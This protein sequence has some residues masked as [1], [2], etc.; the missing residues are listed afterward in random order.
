MPLSGVGASV[1]L[2][3]GSIQDVG[4][5]A[6]R[7]Q[8]TEG[9]QRSSWYDSPSSLELFMEVCNDEIVESEKIKYYGRTLEV[10]VSGSS[11][12]IGRVA[13]L[14][15]KPV[16]QGMCTIVVLRAVAVDEILSRGEQITQFTSLIVGGVEESI[17][18]GSVAADAQGLTVTDEFL[19]VVDSAMDAV[20]GWNIETHTRNTAPDFDLA[21]GHDAA[22]GLGSDGQDRFFVTDSDD[23]LVRQYEQGRGYSVDSSQTMA[24][25]PSGQTVRGIGLLSNLV[26]VDYG[27]G[28][29]AN[30]RIVFPYGAG[31]L[32]VA[33]VWAPT[34]PVLHKGM[35][36]LGM[37]VFPN[38]RAHNF[39]MWRIISGVG[40]LVHNS[41][42]VSNVHGFTSNT[43]RSASNPLDVLPASTDVLYIVQVGMFYY[44]LTSTRIY[45]LTYSTVTFLGANP[46]YEVD[47]SR[48]ASRDIDLA[49]ANA[50]PRFIVWDETY[51]RVWDSANHTFYSYDPDT[52]EE[53]SVERFGPGFSDDIV[54]ATY[55]NGTIQALVE[56]RDLRVLTS[57]TSTPVHNTGGDIATNALYTLSGCV[58]VLSTDTVYV[59][60]SDHNV[61][62]A[63]SRETRQAVP[64]L[65]ID[66][67]SGVTGFDGL[68]SDGQH[69]M[70]VTVD[71][72]LR[73]YR[74]SDKSHN[75]HY[76]AFINNT[77]DLSGV[78]F[79]GDKLYSL[80]SG[81]NGRIDIHSALRDENVLRERERGA[82]RFSYLYELVTGQVLGA[83]MGSRQLP[84][85][86]VSGPVRDSFRRVVDAEPGRLADG[87]FYPHGQ[88][89]LNDA[90]PDKVGL[91]ESEAPLIIDATQF[92]QTPKIEAVDS[93]LITQ[94]E[95]IA[96]D[97]SQ[98]SMTDDDA[99]NTYGLKRRSI[100]VDASV[101]DTES[102]LEWYIDTWGQEFSINSVQVNALYEPDD[103]SSSMV[104]ARPHSVVFID[105]P[106]LVLSRMVVLEAVGDGTLNAAITFHLVSPRQFGVG[107]TLDSPLMDDTLNDRTILIE[108]RY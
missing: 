60:Y 42:L 102:L 81:S 26:M 74:L 65:H 106:W 11:F 96:F 32:F 20:R 7:L 61:I 71:G 13:E 70:G 67:G 103:V 30:Q 14:Q 76:D 35:W 24:V 47:W 104:H 90:V 23:D 49:S 41:F 77:D 86:N 38:D 10:V 18:I 108:A 22:T 68:T 6:F 73:A 85:R 80:Y 25:A 99:V 16:E 97:G 63:Y 8:I 94:L 92:V 21:T 12:W 93:L 78:A 79:R 54:D 19:L 82:V 39:L 95:M 62:E 58:Y 57:A 105:D 59:S 64:S 1:T 2:G 72:H 43:V 83:A 27:L 75:E 56:P 44:A 31:G 48:V 33:G 17:S 91:T 40:S 36:Y 15:F 4:T 50:D 52:Q 29:V 88:W 46:A 55:W 5:L 84:A 34:V 9:R 69:I 101:E 51:L 28:G 3:D 89:R 98:R 107:W 100:N 66:A 45:C 37:S 87:R 53:V